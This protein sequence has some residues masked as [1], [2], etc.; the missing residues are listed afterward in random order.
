MK[1][2]ESIQ[3]IANTVRA[4]RNFGILS[5]RHE[6]G[7]EPVILISQDISQNMVFTKRYELG[8]VVNRG[9]YNGYRYQG[10]R[11]VWKV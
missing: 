7:K 3:P 9:E 8:E 6:T 11:V 2:D 5:I 1:C 4:V 10:C